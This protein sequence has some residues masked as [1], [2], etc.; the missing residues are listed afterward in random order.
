M[1]QTNFGKSWDVSG[2]VGSPL[3]WPPHPSHDLSKVTDSL[4]W[5]CLKT[6]LRSVWVP[7]TE[8]WEHSCTLR[9]ELTVSLDPTITFSLHLWLTSEMSFFCVSSA[10]WVKCITESLNWGICC[11]P[12]L[13]TQNPSW[14]PL[15]QA[16]LFLIT[17]TE[18]WIIS[19]PPQGSYQVVLGVTFSDFIRW[20]QHFVSSFSIEI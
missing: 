3:M 7:W 14:I 8:Q 17:V 1:A 13:D 9:C 10:P 4:G 2:K 11:I 16:L 12:V 6:C 19:K 20:N 18:H 5:G 15:P